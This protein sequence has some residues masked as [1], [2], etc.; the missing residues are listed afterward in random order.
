MNCNNNLEKCYRSNNYMYILWTNTRAR[1][2]TSHACTRERTH[3]HTHA[4]RFYLFKIEQCYTLQY[5][6][7]TFVICRDFSPIF[8]H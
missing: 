1:T 5:R 2:Q 3:A 4:R 7:V 8:R 6:N